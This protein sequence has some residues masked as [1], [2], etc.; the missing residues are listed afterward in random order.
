VSDAPDKF[1]RTRLRAI[2]GIELLVDRV[3]G[4]AK[5]GQNRSEADRAGA[6]AGLRA[7]GDSAAY[8]LAGEMEET[9][10]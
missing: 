1:V 8:V 2:V 9:L 6:V 5:L 4:K 3:E 10:S 7:E